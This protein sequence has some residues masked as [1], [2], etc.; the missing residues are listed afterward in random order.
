M[1][2]ANNSIISFIAAAASSRLN[3]VSLDNYIVATYNYYSANTYKS[4]FVKKYVILCSYDTIGF[5]FTLS[6]LIVIMSPAVFLM[7]NK[8]IL[9]EKKCEAN[10]KQHC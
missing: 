2:H 9:G 10:Q 6:N 4:I 1:L 3:I 5:Y 8:N 7:L